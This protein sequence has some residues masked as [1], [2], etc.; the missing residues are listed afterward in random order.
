MTR[1][2][3]SLVVWHGFPVSE[4]RN[5]WRLRIYYSRRI[6]QFRLNTLFH[7]LHLYCIYYDTNRQNSLLSSFATLYFLRSPHHK[8]RGVL[9]PFLSS[10]IDSI[11]QSRWMERR[12]S[13]HQ[14]EQYLLPASFW[15]HTNQSLTDK[16][17]TCHYAD[18]WWGIHIP[19]HQ[20][21]GG[22]NISSIGNVPWGIQDR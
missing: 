4:M 2:G 16:H 17:I 5:K 13:L 12:L 11:Q 19:S 1:M 9:L 10:S 8:R 18:I 21:E 7:E 3:T 6:S 20:H 15:S 14:L 22:Q